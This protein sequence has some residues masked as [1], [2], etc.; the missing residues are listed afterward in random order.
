MKYEGERD[1]LFSWAQKKRP[2]GLKVYK[3]EKNRRSIDG[4]SGLAE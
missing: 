3:Q 1:Q 2:E 4:L